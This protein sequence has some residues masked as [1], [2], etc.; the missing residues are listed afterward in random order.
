MDRLLG[1]RLRQQERHVPQRV[2]IYR[3]CKDKSLQLEITHTYEEAGD[4]T[5]VVKVIDILGTDKGGA[6]YT[7]G[8]TV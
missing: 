3:T 8:L 1:G 6:A 2:Q 5:I 4:Y 7:K